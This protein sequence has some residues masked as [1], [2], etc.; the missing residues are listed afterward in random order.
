MAESVAPKP[1]LAKLLPEWA[2][3]RATLKEIRGYTDEELIAVADIGYTLIQQGK[4]D[5][6]RILFEGLIAI[7]PANEYYYRALGNI[8]HKLGD[9]ERAIKQFS[10]A[11]RVKPEMPYAYINRAEIYISLNAYAQAE[12]DLRAALDRIDVHEQQLSKKV[13]ALLKVVSHT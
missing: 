3:G 9:S 12:T 11:I 7:D 13:W 10:Y 6:A 1:D 2:S 8:F 4:N 5:D